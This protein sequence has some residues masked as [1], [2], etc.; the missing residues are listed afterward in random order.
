MQGYHCPAAAGGSPVVDA[1]GRPPGPRRTSTAAGLPW[2]D[3][4]CPRSGSRETRGLG[5][6]ARLG[7]SGCAGA[8]RTGRAAADRLQRVADALR[9]DPTWV[10]QPEG[11]PPADLPQ[12]PASRSAP[13]PGDPGQPGGPE[14]APR[15]P[16]RGRHR[17][18][19]AMGPGRAPGR[20]RA[21]RRA[22]HR[23][24]CGRAAAA[25]TGQAGLRIQ[26]WTRPATAA[27][28]G[29]RSRRLRDDGLVYAYVTTQTD[30]RVV[31]FAL[32]GPV[33]PVFTGI[34]RGTH[35]QR[36]PDHVRLGRDAL[37]R[38]R[39][40]RPARAVRRPAEPGRQGAAG[41]HVRPAG[42]GQPRPG[43]AGLLLGHGRLAGL[44]LSGVARLHDRAGT[45]RPDEVNRVEAGRDYGWPGG[46][47]AG[48]AARTG[49]SGRGPPGSAAARSSSAA[50][51]SPPPPASGC[52]AA[53]GRVGPA[54]PPTDYLPARTGGCARSSPARTARCG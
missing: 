44:C 32:K 6:T 45:G 24:V 29:S 16:Q 51:S 15:R 8:A 41:G 39:R 48:A 12:P 47:R 5:E 27:C 38:H 18:D 23:P 49:R 1:A 37:R 4:G 3:T 22:D 20:H 2:R 52:R 31:R 54:G 53:A 21:G 42:Q 40:R 17:A 43:L 19:P 35:R 26:G 11:P 50:C 34:P 7:G 14:P 36:R 33:T 10:P 13:S 30:N 9:P 46:T 25:R 28:S